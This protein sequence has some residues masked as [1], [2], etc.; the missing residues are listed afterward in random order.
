MLPSYRNPRNVPRLNPRFNPSINPRVSTSINPIFNSRINP[1]FNSFINPKFNSS[2]NPKLNSNLNYRFNSR[3]NPKV[4]SCL[5]PRLNVL[6][7]PKRTINFV[8]P[9]VFELGLEWSMFAIPL[10]EYC[11][12]DAYLV[13]SLDFEVKCYAFSNGIDGYNLFNIDN[14]WIGYWVETEVGF[15]EFSV[16]SEWTRFVIV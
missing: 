12:I 14:V 13:Y 1:R 6:V 7:N 5:N 11:N 2:I 8:L 3:L 16:L 15:A 4:N 9:V 10:H